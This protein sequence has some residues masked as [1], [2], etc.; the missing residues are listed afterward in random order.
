MNEWCFIEMSRLE[1][2]AIK[3]RVM[4]IKLFDQVFCVFKI[5]EFKLR[6]NV[7]MSSGIVDETVVDFSVYF[8]VDQT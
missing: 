8:A 3:P 2:R 5:T 6:L 1:K 7:L 4:N